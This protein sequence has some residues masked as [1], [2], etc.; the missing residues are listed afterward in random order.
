MATEWFLNLVSALSE[1][2]KV[3]QI[4]KHT[5][6]E[7]LST[8][9]GLPWRRSPLWMLLRVS[10]QMHFK[11]NDNDLRSP[12]DLY[13]AFMI[14]L[15]LRLLRLAEEHCHHLGNGAL[16]AVLT[17]LERRIRKMQALS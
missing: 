9:S 5:R 11:R 8:G 17:K 14:M 10:L 7:V 16:Y 6:E 13:K 2:A 3:F 4:T 1:S 12:D 15:L